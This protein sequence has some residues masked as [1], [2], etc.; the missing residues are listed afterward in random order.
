MVDTPTQ[1]DSMS[2]PPDQ[3]PIRA[4]HSI[5]TPQS[6]HNIE[7]SLIQ[8]I[9]LNDSSILHEPTC[10]ICSSPHREEL[11][12]KYV[13][14]KNTGDVK[15]LFKTKSELP[16][17]SDII[18][19]HMR[20]HYE[21]GIK[22]LQKIEYVNKIKRLN[23]VEMTTLDRIRLALSVITERLMGINSI[24]PTNDLSSAE[25]EKIKSSETSRLMIAFNNL[26]KLQASIMG[27]MQSSGELII[28]PRQDFIN[29]F[30]K[31]IIEAKTNEEQSVL[32]KL[33]LDLADLGKKT[34]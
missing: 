15:K 30:N 31:A 7:E 33:L 13:E 4:I 22:E 3:T 27:E 28:L 29:I 17:S 1:E 5:C 16:L 18:E 23:T 20:N 19:N 14:T 6:S 11:E 12:K 9:N 24:T 26:L 8:L 32:Q 21:R 10:I 25:V 2:Q 34:Q